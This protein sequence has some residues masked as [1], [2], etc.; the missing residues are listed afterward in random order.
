[1]MPVIRE[2]TIKAIPCGSQ[3]TPAIAYFRASSKANV[4]AYKDSDKRQRAAVQGFAMSN[5]VEVTGARP[6]AA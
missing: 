5:G 3:K 1:M 2:C 4:G 6:W